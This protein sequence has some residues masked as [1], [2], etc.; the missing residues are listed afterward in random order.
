MLAAYLKLPVIAIGGLGVII[1]LIVTQV[2]PKETIDDDDDFE[3]EMPATE[4][5]PALKLGKK[6]IRNVFLR[7]LVLEANFNFETW[8][9]TGFAFAIIP[10][11][12]KLYTTKT[13]MAAALKRHLT[14][15]NTSPYGS[16]LILGI[17][18]AMEEQNSVDADF[19]EESINSVKLGLM[20]PLAGV[21][22]SLFWGTFKVIAAGVGT[23]LAIKG[24]LMGPVLFILI[25]NVPHLLLRYNLTFIGYN[26]G[27]KFLQNLAKNNVMD[28]LTKGA[29]ILGL[30]VVGAMP[31]TLIAINTPIAFGS[32]KSAITLQ[33]VLDQIVPSIIP[34][35]LTFLVYFFVKKNVKTTYLLLG[36]LALG[37]IGSMIHVFA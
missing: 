9:N 25:F 13:T 17:T 11:L 8:Q 31:A 22:D 6:D 21:F 35:G 28:R 10:I 32:A 1:A 2:T 4:T 34:L 27:T 18:T 26:A 33:S 36:L 37:F 19:D 5:K 20:G 7:S 23:S 15:F 16:T 30:M 29:S 12:K 14:F 24:N 3:Q